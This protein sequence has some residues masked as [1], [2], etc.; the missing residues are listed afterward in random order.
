M[1]RGINVN[2]DKL[3][4][5]LLCW[6]AFF[7]PLERI[8]KVFFQVDTIL[9]PYRVL[10]ILII[11]LFALRSRFRWNR[12]PELAEDKY[13]YVIF[14]YGIFITLLRMITNTFNVSLLF[15]DVFQL[16]LY[17]GVFVV[18]RHMGLSKKE[19]VRIFYFLAF[20]VLTNC[21]YVFNK[22]FILK[23]YGRDGGFMDNPNYLAF[24]IQVIMVFM[25]IRFAN[26]KGLVKKIL[27]LIT[28][29]FLG[30]IFILS[31]SRT[32]F[33][34]L[35]VSFML[36]LYFSSVRMKGVLLAIMLAVTIFVSL[37]DPDD[38][39]TTGP[40]VLISRLQ[41]ASTEDNRLPIW[42][43][44]L[45]AAESTS[46]SGLGVG[47]FKARFREF[48]E[49][50]NNQLVTRAVGQGYFLSPH[51]DYLMLLAVYGIVGLVCY[52]IYAYL[53]IRKVFQ[54]F[55]RAS[56]TASKQYYQ[57]GF[58]M[59]ASLLLFGITNENFISALFW[60]VLSLATRTYSQEDDKEESVYTIEE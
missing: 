43:G 39:E 21:I 52:L 44:V 18:V 34:L 50:E 20:G 28:L 4:L 48:Y 53:S 27:W 15:N 29:F 51:S 46:F 25:I 36:M 3:I 56:D 12:N 22:F 57:F 14:L 19:V 6:Y 5:Q 23:Q 17:L 2:L 60:I 45:R 55:R 16:G 54:K 8:L 38:I 37:S 30:Y 33:L 49:E 32:G 24:S 47:Q 35:V 26:V 40:L 31:G 1:S 42:K 11:M 10:A 59:I 7:I 58:L 41:K 13:F 9:K